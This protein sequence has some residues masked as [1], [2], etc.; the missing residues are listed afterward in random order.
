[1]VTEKLIWKALESVKDPELGI[2]IVRL[3]MVKK[4]SA[5]GGKVAVDVALTISGCPL[6]ERVER[7]VTEAVS[8]LDGVRAVQ[9]NLGVMAKEERDELVAQL[10]G[11]KKTELFS[12]QRP[13]KVIPVASGKGGVGKSTVTVNL[14][15]ALAALGYKVGVIDA[16]VYGFSIPQ[17]LGVSGRPT[18]INQMIIPLEKDGVKV[19]SIG[20]LVPED[21]SVIWRGPMLHKAITQFM[22]DVFWGELDFLLLDL[23]PGTGD[24]SITVAQALP[25]AEILIVTTPQKAAYSVAARISKLAEVA[26]LKILGVVENMSFFQTS[27]GEKVQIFGKGGGKE[28]AEKLRVPLLGEIPIEVEIREGSDSGRPVAIYRKDTA[29]GRLYAELAGKLAATLPQPVLAVS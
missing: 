20:F 8:A 9:V 18:V 10:T 16:D 27:G 12:G 21:A 13:K 29:V 28:L 24:V 6:R 14:A 19:I 2:S 25:E 11:R 22:T 1:M 4:V 17:M 7:D 26:H 23:P 3:G 15:V 5:N